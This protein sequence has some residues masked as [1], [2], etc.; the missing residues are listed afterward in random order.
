MFALCQTSQRR[1]WEKKD[2]YIERDDKDIKKWL[3]WFKLYNPFP[4]MKQIIS[5]AAEIIANDT[6]NCNEVRDTSFQS[7]QSMIGQ[8]FDNIK[9][10]RSTDTF[11][12]MC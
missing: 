1:K 4:T 3:G 12:F 7:M 11:A 10:Q 9:L 5:L 2:Y 8:K 6:I